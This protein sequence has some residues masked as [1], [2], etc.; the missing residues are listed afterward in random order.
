[1]LL[2]SIVA[3]PLSKILDCVL[4]FQHDVS[5]HCRCNIP[6]HLKLPAILRVG[7]TDLL[8]PMHQALFRRSQL[9]ALVSLHSQEEGFGGTLS[10]DEIS[11]IR[12]ALDLSSKTASAC[13]T[14]LDKVCL[15]LLLLLPTRMRY[16]TFNKNLT[17]S[18]AR[19]DCTAYHVEQVFMLS[20]DT[21]LSE[22]CLLKILDSGHSRVPVHR[23]GRRC[24]IGSTACGNPT[25]LNTF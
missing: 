14:P 24:N 22:A 12:G 5:P 10:T 11:I 23:P 1:M 4:G 6:C 2:C 18:T 20:S 16:P 7:P 13:M 21:V 17:L 3:W 19:P 25:L 15:L 9:K 8:W